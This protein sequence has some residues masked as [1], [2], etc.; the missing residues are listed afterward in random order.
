M[1]GI[2][3]AA[4]ALLHYPKPK[5]ADMSLG[6]ITMPPHDGPA[7]QSN[8]FQK[9]NYREQM[10]LNRKLRYSNSRPA[11]ASSL[12]GRGSRGSRPGA[13]TADTGLH[14]VA[15]KRKDKGTGLNQDLHGHSDEP[16]HGPDGDVLANT[17]DGLNSSMFGLLGVAAAFRKS[18]AA[19]QSKWRQVQDSQVSLLEF[20]DINWEYAQARGTQSQLQE[21][22]KDVQKSQNRLPSLTKQTRRIAKMS[23]MIKQKRQH[24]N[25]SQHN[26][27]IQIL[28]QWAEGV[29]L[30][31]RPPAYRAN[32]QSNPLKLAAPPQK[33]W[34][35]P[36]K[37]PMKRA[38]A[39]SRQRFRDVGK[40][41]S[42]S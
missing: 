39:N 35:M 5:T 42:D 37:L 32:T 8:E 38:Q 22:H 27:Q 4:H 15:R 7:D 40:L 12:Q 10:K 36:N 20:Q 25:D 18:D 3:L 16:K 2:S 21:E 28:D 13:S 41:S 23:T 33:N 11:A 14:V 24:P 9:R 34:G 1:A 19:Y 6:N 29:D 31:V 30:F 26:V 17:S